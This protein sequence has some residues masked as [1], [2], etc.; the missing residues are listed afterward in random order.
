MKLSASS[1]VNMHISSRT[2]CAIILFVTVIVGLIVWKIQVPQFTIFS[3][4]K[5]DIEPEGW[6]EGNAL[7][8]TFWSITLITDFTEGGYFTTYEF[9]DEEAHGSKADPNWHG[10]NMTITNV[11]KVMVIPQQPY[12]SRKLTMSTSRV[13]PVAYQNYWSPILPF[14]SGRDKDVKADLLDSGHYVFAES[15]WTA[16]TPFNI[17]VRVN[18][19]FFD[20]VVV[21]TVGATNVV[22][23]GDAPNTITLSKLGLI[24]T[25]YE[26]PVWQDIV[27]FNHQNFYLRENSVDKALTSP[28]PVGIE[29]AQGRAT[30]TSDQVRGTY[31]FYWYGQESGGDIWSDYW[32]DEGDPFPGTGVVGGTRYLDRDRSGGWD[33]NDDSLYVRY[34]PVP[35]VLFP[36]Q[37]D[38][39][40]QPYYCVTEYLEK[41]V[42]AKHPTMPSWLPNSADIV[43]TENDEM[44]LY[45]PMGSMNALVNLRVST[46]VADTFVWAPMVGNFKITDF[47][48]FGDVYEQKFWSITVQQLEDLSVPVSGTIWFS[49]EPSLQV[50]VNPPTLGVQLGYLE[51]QTLDFS[52]LNLGVQEDTA[53]SI[54]AT[55]KNS[56]GD[57]T[58]TKTIYGTAKKRSTT[59]T[60]L[61]VY[62]RDH[63]D[64]SPVSNIAV[65]VTYDS[66]SMTAVS[67]AGAVSFDFGSSVPFVTVTTQETLIYKGATDTKQLSPGSNSITIELYKHGD[68]PDGGSLW[69]YIILGV[70][71]ACVVGFA[72]VQKRKTNKTKRR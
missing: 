35:P 4:S 69:P 11:I 6:L 13:T 70:V 1:S 53:F 22:T 32:K 9:D 30:L 61:V 49:V 57:T 28:Y 25:G 8:G 7:K 10:Q 40:H 21:D 36:Q 5:I 39:Y 62:L 56:V 44:R 59:T 71:A 3:V 65:T 66:Q 64:K 68:E 31:A 14:S 46:E 50:A 34:A 17:K 19:E 18:G 38:P 67:T 37:E 43:I 63:T 58:D 2:L 42:G 15:D 26:A 16:H 60:F 41:V 54:T 72:A 55:V 27:W 12:Y 51:Q 20:D 48:D 47:N 33:Y 29:G 52:I 24:G 23:L 45:L